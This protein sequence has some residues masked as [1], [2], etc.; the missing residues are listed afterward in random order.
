MKKREGKISDLQTLFGTEIQI[1][2]RG[3]LSLCE[4]ENKNCLI[5]TKELLFDCNFEALES[6]VKELLE[7]I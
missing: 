5:V 4:I 6:F 7:S 2:T 1:E 3:I